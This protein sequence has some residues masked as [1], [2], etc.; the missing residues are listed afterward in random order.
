MT[1]GGGW[2]GQYF[3]DIYAFK[4]MRWAD[5]GQLLSVRFNI[6]TIFTK[7]LSQSDL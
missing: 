3:S 6:S 5:I 2:A 4:N 7:I 1:L